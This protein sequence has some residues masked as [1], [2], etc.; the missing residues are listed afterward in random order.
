MDREVDA[1]IT[2]GDMADIN[3]LD[4]V[5]LKDG[6]DLDGDATSDFDATGATMEI[7][8]QPEHGTAALGGDGTLVYTPDEG[9]AGADSVLWSVNLRKAPETVIG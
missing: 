6:F 1:T 2:S 8:S 9:Y 5:Y 7:A 3:V 4:E